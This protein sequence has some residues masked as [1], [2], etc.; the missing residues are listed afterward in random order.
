M[1]DFGLFLSTVLQASRK[2]LATQIFYGRVCLVVQL[3]SKRGKVWEFCY[4]CD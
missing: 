4:K 1:Q 2:G 3:V